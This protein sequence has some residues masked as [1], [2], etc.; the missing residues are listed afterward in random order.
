MRLLKL[1]TILGVLAA[2]ATGAYALPLEFA[3]LNRERGTLYQPTANTPNGTYTRSIENNVPVWKDAS[4]NYLPYV[5]NGQMWDNTED[6][7]GLVWIQNMEY[8]QGTGNII[9]QE[10]GNSGGQSYL[11]MFWGSQDQSVEV[12][13][14]AGTKYYST[15]TVGLNFKI[16]SAN[17]VGQSIQGLVNSLDTSVPANRTAQDAFSGWT[18]L[19]GATPLLSGT[20]TYMSF[21]TFTTGGPLGSAS[22]WASVNPTWG[23]WSPLWDTN[24]FTANNSALN[25][26]PNGDSD[27]YMQWTLDVQV[28]ADGALVSSD[29]GKA[30]MIPEPVT[31]LGLM[32]GVG[33][34]AGYIRKRRTV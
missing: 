22:L 16:W 24:M 6:G 3:S 8:P 31:M 17:V 1:C 4:N 5:V 9:Y 27:M 20:T 25:Y 28:A 30:D 19:S 10:P 29:L 15:T 14:V 2:L 34:L 21:T 23:S 18:N 26:V 33:G 12:F 13:S 7:W 32:L 11:G